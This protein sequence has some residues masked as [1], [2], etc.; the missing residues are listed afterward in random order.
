MF[1]DEVVVVTNVDR[2]GSLKHGNR[3]RVTCGVVYIVCGR[4][5]STP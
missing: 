1:I 3:V 2:E 4:S 5:D